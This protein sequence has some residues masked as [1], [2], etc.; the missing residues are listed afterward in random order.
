MNT[1]INT[2]NATMI[3]YLYLRHTG[4]IQWRPVPARLG[5]ASVLGP[6]RLLAAAG[7]A[8]TPV[9]LVSANHAIKNVHI[10]A[11]MNPIALDLQYAYNDLSHQFQSD[12][13]QLVS[14]KLARNYIT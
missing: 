9:Q 13:S 5:V 4:D 6:V 10:R 2:R 3:F 12:S 7:L 8:R 1:L 14:P 11:Q